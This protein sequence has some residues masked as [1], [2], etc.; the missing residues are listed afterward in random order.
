MPN[1]VQNADMTSEGSGKRVGARRPADVPIAV[2]QELESGR[3]E[4]V[5]LMEQIAIDQGTL[6]AAIIPSA[7]TYANEM[8][9]TRLT[10]RM[11]EGARVLLELKG[12][13]GIE[14]A[15][16][17]RSDTARGWG[18]M[19]IGLLPASVS[20]HARLSLAKIF[21]RDPHFTVREWAWIAVRPQVAAN[22]HSAIALLEQWA[23]DDDS[24]VRRFASE[25][26]RPR[27]VWCRHIPLLKAT[28]ELAIELLQPLHADPA[29]Y[30]Q[31]SVGNWLNDAARTRPDWTRS[32]CDS[33]SCNASSATAA[34]IRRG[35]RSFPVEPARN[36]SAD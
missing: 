30:V 3:C 32:T 6:L 33:W 20:L 9:T 29:R 1:M 27:G 22:I 17:W 23:V 21:A 31:L 28:P 24:S 13:E 5:N 12:R 26:T 18:A 10:D 19:A 8:R 2:R 4:T 14:E 34:I 7:K 15:T 16:T 25:V 11:R 35:L 36:G